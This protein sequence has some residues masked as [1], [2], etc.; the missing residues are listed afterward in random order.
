VCIVASII[1]DIL[2]HSET[3]VDKRHFPYEL[4]SKQSIESDD[5][6]TAEKIFIRSKGEKFTMLAVKL[7]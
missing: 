5:Y 3:G 6:C 7:S 1:I 2:P 4:C